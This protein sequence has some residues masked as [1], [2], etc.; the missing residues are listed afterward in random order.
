MHL[1]YSFASYRY[2][3]FDHELR[4]TECESISFYGIGVVDFH[5]PEAL[6]EF[7]EFSSRKW[8]HR[9]DLFHEDVYLVD[10]FR[11]GRELHVGSI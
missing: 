8:P 6:L 5:H 10:E 11:E 4:L 1:P 3:I 9:G 7:S 2:A